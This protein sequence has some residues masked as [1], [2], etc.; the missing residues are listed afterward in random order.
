MKTWS[1]MAFLF[2]GLTTAK[3]AKAEDLPSKTLSN[4]AAELANLLIAT[5]YNKSIGN[6]VMNCV[7]SVYRLSDSGYPVVIKVVIQEGNT[8][9]SKNSYLGHS[10]KRITLTLGYSGYRGNERPSVATVETEWN[11]AGESFKYN[12]CEVSQLR[13]KPFK[14]ITHIGQDFTKEYLDFS[15]KA[16]P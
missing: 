8:R 10:Y 1:L 2:F 15:N 5:T 4:D 9:D 13:G 3:F 7:E 14:M 12:K 11:G 6:G 16:R